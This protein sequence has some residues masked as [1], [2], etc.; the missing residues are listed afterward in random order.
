VA[1]GYPYLLAV[2]LPRIFKSHDASVPSPLTPAVLDLF[3]E[4]E[5]Q[6]DS[7]SFA[8]LIAE[9]CAGVLEGGGGRELLPC[10]WPYC[11]HCYIAL[12][13]SQDGALKAACARRDEA[14]GYLEKLEGCLAAQGVPGGQP[15]GAGSGAAPVAPPPGLCAALA[16]EEAELREA[17]QAA[18][19][20]RARA[21]AACA[22]AAAQGATL[23]AATQAP[24][25]AAHREVAARLA[26]GRERMD[27]LGVECTRSREA[28]ERLRC[29]RVQSDAFFI[30]HSEPFATINGA[31]LGRVPGRATDWAEI[32][33][34]LGQLALLL[35]LTAARLRY[36]FKKWRIIPMGSYSKIALVEDEKSSL[37]ELSYDG[38][39]LFA[40]ARLSKALQPLVHCVWELGA[41]VEATDNLFRLPYPMSSGGERVGDLAVAL[42]KEVPWT[43]AMRMI[44]TNV[45]WL[46]AYAEKAVP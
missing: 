10:G 2:I 24:L 3:R 26:A 21:A 35:S 37:L 27:A 13:A 46:V 42:G 8:V 22:R 30:W 20:R 18:Q 29:L 16:R 17:L 14:Q 31:R 28:L 33:A 36:V 40:A 41:H 44:A 45:K 12:K 23:A 4:C 15:P 7:V 9:L 38:S 1:C 11:D 19:A 25:W 43:R 39:V 32:N 6:R 34:A 5:R